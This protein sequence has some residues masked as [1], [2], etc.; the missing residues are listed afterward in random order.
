LAKNKSDNNRTNKQPQ[1]KSINW[2]AWIMGIIVVVMLGLMIWRTNQS[3]QNAADESLAPPVDG[4]RCQTMEGAAQHEHSHLAL[5]QNGQPVVVP[6]NIGIPGPCMYWLHTHDATGEI[7]V[8][9]PEIRTFTLGQFF[10]IWGKPLT[11]DRAGDVKDGKP[12][13]MFVDGK[14]F[15]GDPRAIELKRHTQITLEAGPTYV[16]PPVFQFPA[17]D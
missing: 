13:R 11:A 2:M 6:A 8:E 14:P 15:T 16:D 17:S 1:P 10:D 12:L 3:K 4:I 5:F 9:S 7:H